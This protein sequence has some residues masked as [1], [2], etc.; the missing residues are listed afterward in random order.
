MRTNQR[1]LG[2]LGSCFEFITY[3]KKIKE[4]KK[5][6]KNVL[7]FQVRMKRY[8]FLLDC[9]TWPRWAG[10]WNQRAP[11]PGRPI[12][13]REKEAFNFSIGNFIAGKQSTFLAAEEKPEGEFSPRPRFRLTASPSQSC[14][15]AGGKAA[16]PTPQTIPKS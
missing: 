9:S 12:H 11:L 1:Q 14:R 4:E 6:K 2:R 10:N 7:S 5:E 8:K 16:A 15:R 13:K 3:I